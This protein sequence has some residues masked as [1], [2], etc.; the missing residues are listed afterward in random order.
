MLI[1]PGRPLRPALGASDLHRGGGE[2]ARPDRL[3][4]F[5]F[6]PGR[7][8]GRRA[9]DARQ[10]REAQAK[11]FREIATIWTH[12]QDSLQAFRGHEVPFRWLLAAQK[13]AV[14]KLQVVPGGHVSLVWMLLSYVCGHGTRI[15]GS[16]GLWQPQSPSDASSIQSFLKEACC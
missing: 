12:K 5:S 3:H 13:T 4:A 16:M 7:A 6:S 14:G 9:P 8:R 15:Q 2:R 10:H 11:R 1:L